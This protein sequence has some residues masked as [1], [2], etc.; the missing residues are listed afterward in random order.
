MVASSWG[1]HR[2]SPRMASQPDVSHCPL[3]SRRPAP[4][5]LRRG[6]GSCLDVLVGIFQAPE[7]RLRRPRGRDG[8]QGDHG[9]CDGRN[10]CL[11]VRCR[12]DHF[13]YAITFGF[14]F[15]A[16]E[17]WTERMPTWMRVSSVSE[18]KH[19]LVGIIIVYLIVD[20]ATDIA[21]SETHLTW[22]TLVMPLSIL[23]VAGTLRLL[24]G[25]HSNQIHES[26]L[27]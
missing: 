24:D 19:T 16:P 15:E 6:A 18:L 10:R 22:E 27:G 17:R 11:P 8:R 26:R 23:L 4:G 20:F 9:R 3:A 5:L 25:A 13:A 2:I 1:A 14:V 12:A 21:A 7:K